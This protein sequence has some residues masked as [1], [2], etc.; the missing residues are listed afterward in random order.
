MLRAAGGSVMALAGAMLWAG[1]GFAQEAPDNTAKGKDPAAEEII[2]TAQFRD[3]KLQDV[4]I[5]ITAM[6]GAMLEQR[7]QTNLVDLGGKAPNVTLR[8]ASANFGPAVVA[9]FAALA[10]AIPRSRSNRAWASMST[11]SI[12]RRCRDRC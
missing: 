7:G 5:A 12:C 2:V 4:P 8:T 3:Q 6:S 10:S 1:P 9:T 11:T